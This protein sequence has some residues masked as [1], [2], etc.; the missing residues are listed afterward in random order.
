MHSK[1]T[2]YL[3]LVRD[4]FSFS[5]K[6]F[7]DLIR[8]SFMPSS[9]LFLLLYIIDVMANKSL[10][11]E[12]FNKILEKQPDPLVYFII[13]GTL[14]S[15]SYLMKILVQIIFDNFIKSNYDYRFPI[16][17]TTS[18]SCCYEILRK[19]TIEK[20]KKIN[21]A[22]EELLSEVDQNNNDYILY[23]IIGSIYKINTRSYTDA[24]KEAGVMALSI[25]LASLYYLFLQ[26]NV[27][28]FLDF[29]YVLIICIVVWISG[30]YYIKSR[31]QAR[32]YRI[33]I[34]LLNDVYKKRS[35]DE[36]YNS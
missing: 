3:T 18:N 36:K 19:N 6:H 31:Y 20:L 15:I 7:E 24:A 8:R 26:I 12:K 1:N 34:N 5:W 4:F 27:L 33:Y 14:L 21:P 2:N 9:F 25:I 16:G 22:I 11:V 17:T 29:A 10:L 28:S 30:Y 32:A 35:L 13:V 23:Q